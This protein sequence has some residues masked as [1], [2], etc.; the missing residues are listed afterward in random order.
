MPYTDAG[1]KTSAQTRQQQAADLRARR[2]HA[3]LPLTR[4][5]VLKYMSYRDIADWLTEQGI[6]TNTKAAS[7]LFEGQPK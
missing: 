7:R 4:L 5:D 2:H 6:D 3:L 1:R